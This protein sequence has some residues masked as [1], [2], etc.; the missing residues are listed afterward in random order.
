MSLDSASQVHIFFWFSTGNFAGGTTKMIIQKG[1][2]RYCYKSIR[3]DGKPKSIYLGKASSPK[4]RAYTKRKEEKA[5][6]RNR[7]QELERL[8]QEVERALKIIK[9][10]E[11]AYILLAGLY[12]RKSEIRKLQEEHC[13]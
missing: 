1:R 10:T 7:E 5:Q 8:N 4:A 12:Q 11:R 9:L 3:I 2:N 6:L 13:V